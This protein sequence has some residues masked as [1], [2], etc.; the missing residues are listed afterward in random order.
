MKQ[1]LDDAGLRTLIGKIKDNFIQN[2]DVATT[3]NLGIS[4]PDGST[5]VVNNGTLSINNDLVNLIQNAVDALVFKGTIGVNGTITTLPN[6]HKAGWTYKVSD[7]E[8]TLNGVKCEL[9]D[10]IIC[11]TS[12]NTANASHWTIVQS[13]ID[14][15]VTS[16]STNV[17]D[18]Y[19]PVF[20]GTTGK[21]IKDPGTGT[22]SLGGNLYVGEDFQCDG[23]ANFNSET[24]FNGDTNFGGIAA[25]NDFANFS[26][27][28]RFHSD[29]HLNSDVHINGYTSY[30]STIPTTNNGVQIANTQFVHNLLNE[31][32][33]SISDEEIQTIFN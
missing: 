24:N 33:T 19:I 23:T 21:I 10:L 1:Y 7:N 29:V 31:Q 5:I 25:F 28:A 18:G 16:T 30:N 17:K 32:V 15:A 9:G 12:G 26:S 11:I 27:A 13:N 8:T 20:N 6:P 2:N 22:A 4:K 14:G 3:S